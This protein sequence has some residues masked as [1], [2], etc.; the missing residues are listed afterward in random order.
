MFFQDYSISLC[1]FKIM[2]T[3][4]K[5]YLNP[6]LGVV[7]LVNVPLEHEWSALIIYDDHRGSWRTGVNKDELIEIPD[8]CFVKQKRFPT[9]INYNCPD[10]NTEYTIKYNSPKC[11]LCSNANLSFRKSIY[12]F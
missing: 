6:K 4:G 1:L 12:T 2:L 7:K 10:C 5:Y 11:F 8:N 3:E 9:N